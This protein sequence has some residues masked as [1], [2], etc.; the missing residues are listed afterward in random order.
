MDESRMAVH[1][2]CSVRTTAVPYMNHCRGAPLLVAMPGSVRCDSAMPWHELWWLIP[3]PPRT[4]HLQVL[5]LENTRFDAGDEGNSPAYAAALTHGA[6]AFVL[7]AFGVCHRDQ[8]SVTGVA[9]RVPQRLMGLLV[10]S[11]LRA[12]MQALSD[13]GRCGPA[14]SLFQRHW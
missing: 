14:G 9:R 10:E 5:L 2:T 4:H 3:L 11:E 13:P 6:D 7:D 1:L 12:M 8:A